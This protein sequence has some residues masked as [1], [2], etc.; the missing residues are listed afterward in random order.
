MIPRTQKR[1]EKKLLAHEFKLRFLRF[2]LRFTI[3]LKRL[4]ENEK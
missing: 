4:L 3:S 2:E 1:E